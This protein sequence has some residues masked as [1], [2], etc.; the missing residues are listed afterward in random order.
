MLPRAR[1]PV[2][3]WAA[4]LASAG[5]VL[6]QRPF[7]EYPP[8]EGW[9]T[10]AA[11][12]P[13][14]QARTELVLGRLMY[15]SSGYRGVGGFGRGGN[16]LEGGTAWTVDYP[17]GDRTFAAILRRLTRVDVRSV[18]QPVNPDDGDD[19]YNWPYLHVAL[20]GAWSLTEAQAAKIRD[21]LMRGGFMLCDSFFGT[22]EWEGFMD[23]IRMI[24]P[25]SEIEELAD[26]DP[27][28]HTLY[29]LNERF[30]IGNFRV[31]MYRGVPYRADGI[32]PHWRAI[33]D[34]K[35]R[36]I[37]AI[38]FNSDLGDSWHMADDPRYPEKY[39]SLGM[40]LGINYVIYSMSH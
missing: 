26:D 22:D 8:L 37:V 16:W 32:V 36:V 5:L 11:L 19:I 12:P 23:G 31:M 25:G 17:K 13:D 38:T 33:R 2:W 20:P 7:R 30:Q 29:D 34:D 27:I 40:R 14:Y 9:D 10:A 18:E 15:P 21:Y 39:S 4:V 24:L 28:F 35:G 1:I 6:A 3:G